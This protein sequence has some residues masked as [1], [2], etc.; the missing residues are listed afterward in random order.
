MKRKRNE[1]NLPNKSRRNKSGKPSKSAQVITEKDYE[2]L[3]KSMAEFLAKWGQKPVGGN[4][5]LTNEIGQKWRN[6]IW[7]EVDEVIRELDTGSFNSFAC[8]SRPGNTY[9]QCLRGSNGWHLEARITW[10]DSGGA[11]THL[12]ACRPGISERSRSLKVANYVSRGQYRDLLKTDDVLAAFRA[13]HAN[14]VGPPLIW[15]PID[16]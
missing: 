4:I 16:V 1:S 15:R 7:L 8:L 2:E 12:R 14:K 6:P 9:M 3:E 11:Y 10:K 5:V 13:F